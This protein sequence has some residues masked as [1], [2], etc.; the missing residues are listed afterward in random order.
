MVSIK[1]RTKPDGTIFYYLEHSVRIGSKVGKKTIYLGKKIPSN[2][3]ELKTELFRA[4]YKDHYDDLEIIKR[5]Y[6]KEIKVIPKSSLIKSREIFA[7]RFTYDT[8]RIEGSTLSLRDTA[9]LLE[10]GVTP[11][12]KPIGDIKEAEAHKKL[13]FQIL[14]SEKDLSLKTILEWHKILFQDTKSDIAGKIREN[15][16]G[17]SGSKFIPPLPVE[18]YPLVRVFLSWY[19]KNRE[20]THPV[21]L[22]ALMHLKFVTIH[23]FGDGNGRISRLIMNF[24][25]RKKGYPLFNIPYEGRNSYYNALERSQI[26]KEPHYFLLWFI[27]NYIKDNKTYLR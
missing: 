5:N 15:R 19:Q 2:I 4:A 7:T 26:K 13:F 1:K 20:K 14:V 18:I 9:N 27:K 25:L 23:P 10:R 21:E 3:D 12:N 24:I 22:A 17:I 6:V 8:Q 11:K 16:V